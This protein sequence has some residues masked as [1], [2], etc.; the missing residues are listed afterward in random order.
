MPVQQASLGIQ[1]AQVLLNVLNNAVKFT[2]SGEILLEVWAEELP[3]R[4]AAAVAAVSAPVA[5]VAAAAAPAAR[6]VQ[7]A[8]EAEGCMVHFAVRDTG[9]GI[10]KADLGRLFQS[11]SQAGA[12]WCWVGG[13][14]AGGAARLGGGGSLSCLQHI[15]TSA[16]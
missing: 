15:A 10:A 12:R 1:S 11:F 8:E 14:A 16:A 5:A 2:P 7:W 3:R 6:G 4:P 13:G 9:I